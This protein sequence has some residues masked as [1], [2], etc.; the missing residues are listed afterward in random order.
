MRNP[1]RID[2]FLDKVV[3]KY[4]QELI[5]NI[6][7]IQQNEIVENLIYSIGATKETIR[8]CWKENPDLRFSQVLISLGFPN[9]PGFWFYM[10]ED[11]ILQKLSK[12]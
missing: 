3:P 7:G 12:L 10:E 6:W 8:V 1:N 2:P 4:T 11:E 5:V 9:Y